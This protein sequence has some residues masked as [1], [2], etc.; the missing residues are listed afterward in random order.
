M[1]KGMGEKGKKRRYVGEEE[2]LPPQ[3]C[4][5]L[6]ASADQTSISCMAFGIVERLLQ[7]D[8][9]QRQQQQQQ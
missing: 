6:G 7:T 1:G 8:D 2:R 9:H 3:S 5:K 4:I